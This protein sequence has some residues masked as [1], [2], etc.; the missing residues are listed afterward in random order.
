MP[1]FSYQ[2]RKSSGEKIS[3]QLEGETIRSIAENLQTKH[4]I[5]IKIIEIQK[6]KSGFKFNFFGK[7]R[8]EDL[9]FF[10]RQMYALYRA[11]VPI[12]NAVTRI[13]ETTRS[14]VLKETLKKIVEKLLSGQNLTNSMRQYPNVFSNLFTNLIDSGE[15]SGNLDHVFLQLASYLDLE[16]K[17]RAQIKSAT[18]YPMIV[19]G[20][21]FSAIMI[22]NFF[23]IPT[24]AKLFKNFNLELPWPTKVL[25]GT[26]EF[27]INHAFSM[28]GLFVISIVGVMYAIKTSKGRLIWDQLVLKWPV[29]GSIFERIALHDF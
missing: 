9:V 8:S 4:L 17:T 10:C 26:S 15:R 25:I 29:M 3:G 11:G 22:I 1:T 24:F 21:L 6:K 28:I 12:V 16:I 13:S 23:I 19:I 2:A 5:P 27:M 18:R 7:V 20:A 14:P